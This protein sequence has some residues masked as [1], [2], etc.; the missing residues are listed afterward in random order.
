MRHQKKALDVHGTR[1]A[2][3]EKIENGS[4][5][6]SGLVDIVL[7]VASMR[8]APFAHLELLI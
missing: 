8:H 1:Y 6:A 7:A 4:G 2:Q 3:D 5:P